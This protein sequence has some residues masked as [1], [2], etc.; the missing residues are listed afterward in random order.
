MLR[1][2]AFALSMLF[3]PFLVLLF[4]LPGFIARG[5]IATWMPAGRLK[6]LLLRRL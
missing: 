6:Q 5:V 3:K 1:R 4:L 2:M